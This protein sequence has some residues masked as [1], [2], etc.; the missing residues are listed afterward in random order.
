MSCSVTFG[1]D[2][3]SWE[4][5]WVGRSSCVSH[6][7]SELTK[8]H[9][10]YAPNHALP[11]SGGAATLEACQNTCGD[12]ASETYFRIWRAGDPQAE[13]AHV[14]QPSEGMTTKEVGAVVMAMNSCAAEANS[15]HQDEAERQASAQFR[16]CRVTRCNDPDPDKV[17]RKR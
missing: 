6:V 4:M 2:L 17:L 9:R 12:E 15:R 8:V 3:R 16:S 10:P 1:A 13:C 11:G 14:P 5:R 7:T